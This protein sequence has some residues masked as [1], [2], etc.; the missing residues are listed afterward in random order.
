MNPKPLSFPTGARET[1]LGASNSPRE[2]AEPCSECGLG[3]EITAH[4][5]LEANSRLL[6]LAGAGGK[7]KRFGVHLK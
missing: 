4:R 7:R 2:I 5:S 6:R 1:E 3:A